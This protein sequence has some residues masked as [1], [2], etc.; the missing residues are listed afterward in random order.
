MS[1]TGRGTD[2]RGV[3]DAVPRGADGRR[4]LAALLRA[5]FLMSVRARGISQRRVSG[6]SRGLWAVGF[7]YA[8]AG[9]A[10]GVIALGHPDVFTFATLVHGGTLLMA[11]SITGVI[12]GDVLF[13][14]EEAEVIGFRPV[15]PGQLL[16]AK[17]INLAAVAALFGLVFNLAPSLLGLQATGARPW[18]P[19]A[20]VAV[21]V[22]VA[23]FAAAVQVFLYGLLARWVSRER[24]ERA[25]AVAQGVLSVGMILAWQIM[26]RLTERVGGLHLADALPG[27][28]LAPPAWFGALEALLAGAGDARALAVPAAAGVAMTALLGWLAVRRL[29]PDLEAPMA[30]ARVTARR[31]AH[32]GR[33]AP[34]DAGARRPRRERPMPGLLR[35]WLRDPV[36]RGAFRLALAYLRRD[37]ELLMRLL[38][39]ISPALAM[40]LVATLQHGAGAHVPLLM[41]AVWLALTPITVLGLLEISSHSAAA[42]VFRVAPLASPAALFHGARK[43]V[44]LVVVLPTCLVTALLALA[45]LRASGPLLIGLVPVLLLMPI[46]ELFPALWGRW[47]PLARDPQRGLEAGGRGGRLLLSFGLLMP[48]AFIAELPLSLAVLGTIIAIELVA[49]AGVRALLLRRVR[50]LARIEAED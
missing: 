29:A 11:L 49:V 30:G 15:P 27:L 35:A 31:E 41:G 6:R 3:T 34:A 46:V 18:F 9:V 28:G 17:A 20:H 1:A 13:N 19:L 10:M 38:P 2:G 43:A 25:A 12:A 7:G 26:P 39:A 23:T 21:S 16:M 8:L 33:A 45:V 40:V 22:L 47:L 44:M 36:E 48:V 14:R 32:A 42:E 5:Y 4:Q 37:R 50:A 24:L